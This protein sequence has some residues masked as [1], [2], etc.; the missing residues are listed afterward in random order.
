MDLQ[1]L[2]ERGAFVSAKPVKKEVVWKHRDPDGNEVED[3]FD[4]WVR[5]LSYGLVE[6]V[7]APVQAA[8]DSGLE[9]RPRRA[10]KAAVIAAA[11]ELDNRQVISYEDA[12]QLDSSLG[13][14]LYLAV[15]EVNALPRVKD[16]KDEDSTEDTSGPKD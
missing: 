5:K 14:A 6:E 10:I 2:R 15:A 12:Y 7:T 1:Q 13:S 4:V 8:I 9:R 3:R 11:I 16:K